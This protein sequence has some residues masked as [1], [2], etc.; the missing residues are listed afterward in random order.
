LEEATRIAPHDWQV[1]AQLGR[2]NSEIGHFIAAESDFEQAVTIEP[3][4]ASLHFQLGQLYRKTGAT[5][6]A[7]HEL[8]LAQQLL[9]TSSSPSR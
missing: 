4:R 8:A 6:K 1:L 5:E 2:L 9:G 7:T 3:N